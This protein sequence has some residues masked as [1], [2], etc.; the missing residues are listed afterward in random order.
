MAWRSHHFCVPAGIFLTESPKGE[1]ALGIDSSATGEDRKFA[2]V[3]ELLRP[4]VELE[5][6]AP[7][8]YLAFARRYGL[9]NLC[10]H[11]L[12][13]CHQPIAFSSPAQ[14]RRYSFPCFPLILESG[15]LEP[16]S[17]WRR[18]S[19]AARAFLSIAAKLAVGQPGDRDDWRALYWVS[20]AAGNGHPVQVCGRD[21][22]G[23]RVL[24]AGEW[25]SLAGELERWCRL[26]NV[27]PVLTAAAEGRD[28]DIEPVGLF[29]AIAERLVFAVAEYGVISPCGECGRPIVTATKPRSD[30]PILCEPCA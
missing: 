30:R 24:L 21:P 11:G 23:E 18:F 4:F 3:P 16:L 1:P 7:D 6:E 13:A 26:G 17:T 2:D 22:A 12:P 15:G 20:H 5:G 8:A 29:P 9:L 19:R 28:L 14:A 27:R 25:A 10:R